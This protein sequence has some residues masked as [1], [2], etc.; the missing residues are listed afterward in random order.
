MFKKTTLGVLVCSTLL[1]GCA[2]E[3]IND[4]NRKARDTADEASSLIR[5]A[6]DNRPV[7]QF[8][9]SQFVST[10]PLPV[11]KYDAPREVVNCNMP[12]RAKTPQDIWQFSQDIATVCHIRTRVT[13]DAAAMLGGGRGGQS[14]SPTQQLTSVPS[15]ALSASGE[16]R[17]L[18]SFGTGATA[19]VTAPASGISRTFSDVT[20]SGNLGGLLDIVTARLGI[21]WKYEDG[22]VTFFYLQTARFDIE[23]SDAKYALTG[24]V[25]SGVSNSSSSDG[26]GGS[27]SSGSSGSS[28]GVSGESGTSLKSDVSMG[29]NLYDDLKSTAESMLT[30]G[31]G[32]LDMNKTTG[33][34]VITD[35]PEVV[36]RIGE[37]L[38]SENKALSRQVNLK[39]VIY[40]VNTN[41]SDA[42]GID[43]N[44]VYKTLA[45][46]YGINLAGPAGTVA[47]AGSLSFS[48]LDTAT[49]SA[50]QFAGSSFLFD[51]L[52]KQANVSDV[53]TIPLMTT[54][55]ASASVVV[56]RQISYLKSVSTT[57]YSTGNSALPSQ[58]LTPGSVTTG[59]NI[60]I[61]P[62]I[63][64][65]GDRM[66]LNMF[67]NISSL[68]RLREISS[69]T[70]KLEAPEVDSRSVPQ[71]VWLKPGQTVVISGLE[72]NVSSGSKQ[73]MFSPDN[74]VTGGQRSGDKTRQSFVITVTPYIR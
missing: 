34:V 74:L 67:L 55:M 40:T 49:G 25:V 30:P 28:G 73:G 16:M 4:V 18:D 48:V 11:A 53:R 7:V 10:V 2:L 27:G 60:T 38:T 37:Y 45:G 50:K 64:D 19:A 31:V 39:V 3:R 70:E 36:R 17:P 35:V 66:M 61:F 62:K 21:S 5:Q 65:G 47:D 15:P 57:V 41:T 1:Q 44:V 54:N 42:V 9:D 69:D 51:A 68:I 72:Q 8:Q 24:S 33:T 29:N 26:G 12:Y 22:M 56:G 20:Y 6:A 13:P 63:L 14:G 52:S 43:W 71:R 59:T 58:T 46:K 32:R 23:P